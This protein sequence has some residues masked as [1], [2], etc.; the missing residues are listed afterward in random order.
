MSECGLPTASP[1]GLLETSCARRGQQREVSNSLG[2]Q[3]PSKRPSHTRGRPGQSTQKVLPRASGNP[4]LALC[5]RPR[6]NGRHAVFTEAVATHQPGARATRGTLGLL[7][8]LLV[9]ASLLSACASSG[10]ASTDPAAVQPPQQPVK[11]AAPVRLG[12]AQELL[13]AS[14]FGPGSADVPSAITVYA[15]R[16]H[17]A[18][19][20]RIRPITPGTHW[21]SADVKVC[22]TKPVIFG[23]PAWVLGDDSGRTA[24][25][26]RVLHPQFPQPTFPNSSPKAGCARGWV[27]WVTADDLKPTQVTFEQART[28]SV[29]WRIR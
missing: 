29:P 22:R 2:R 25:Q 21:A 26:T 1:E 6:E 14:S 7:G 8:G 16:D 28:V 20:R 19:D 5:N 13:V 27:T 12:A 24:Q 17:V 4:K 9:A 10:G 18:P 23:Y 15:V 11:I 3:S